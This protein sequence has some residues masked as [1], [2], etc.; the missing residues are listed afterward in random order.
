MPNYANA[1]DVMSVAGDI[2]ET[3]DL[4]GP[5]A[6]A[7]VYVARIDAAGVGLDADTLRIIASWL[8]AHFW[9]L[10]NPQYKAEKTGDASVTYDQAPRGQGFSQTPYG[11][12]ALG[13]DTSGV[14]LAADTTRT[15][16]G[17]TWLGTKP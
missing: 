5:L 6:T 10:D 12:T 1:I 16:A 2:P 13:L 4:A 8:A 3:V 7:Q 9:A 15:R 14:L 17:V 11:Q